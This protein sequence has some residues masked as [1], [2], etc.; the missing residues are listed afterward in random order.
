MPKINHITLT[1]EKFRKLDTTD[2]MLVIEHQMV[3]TILK[4]IGKSK[5]AEKH[6]IKGLY[7][8]IEND[9]YISVY[10]YIDMVPAD[11]KTLV[12]LR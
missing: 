3:K 12:K 8:L 5:T 7:V 9:K 10:G 4:T 11:Y 6:G 2:Y 1:I